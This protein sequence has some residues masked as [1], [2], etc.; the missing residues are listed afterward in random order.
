MQAAHALKTAAARFRGLDVISGTG[1][2]YLNAADLARQ[3]D[4]QNV[5]ITPQYVHRG[6]TRCGMQEA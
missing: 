6:E 1:Q 5:Q 3:S 4:S 2:E